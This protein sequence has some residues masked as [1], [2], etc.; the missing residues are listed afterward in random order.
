MDE[1]DSLKFT[2]KATMAFARSLQEYTKRSRRQQIL[3][4][5]SGVAWPQKTN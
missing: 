5:V 1:H 2:R 4:V 3:E